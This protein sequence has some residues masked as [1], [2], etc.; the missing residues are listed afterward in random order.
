MSTA[1]LLVSKDVFFWPIVKDA[2]GKAGCELIVARTLEDPKLAE[3]QDGSVLCCLIDLASL[4]ASQ[5]AGTV[6]YLHRK[7]GSTVRCIAFG[8]HVQEAKLAAAVAAGC[9][10]VLSRGKFTAKLPELLE[11]WTT[12]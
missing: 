9:S 6:E 11:L 7:F 10:P 2:A 3:L 1:V 12:R 4:N 8:P 5:I